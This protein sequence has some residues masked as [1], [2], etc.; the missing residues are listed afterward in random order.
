MSHVRPAP[1]ALPFGVLPLMAVAAVAAVAAAAALSSVRVMLLLLPGET[2]Q[3]GTQQHG[4]RRPSPRA[5]IRPADLTG[6]CEGKAED[7]ISLHPFLL[8]GLTVS[9][10]LSREL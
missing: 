9:R 3:P 4:R 8:I 1:V 10:N 6:T 5:V 7:V 2:G